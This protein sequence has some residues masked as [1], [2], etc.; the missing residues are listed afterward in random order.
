MTEEIVDKN[1]LDRQNNLTVMSAVKEYTDSMMVNKTY[2]GT[3]SFYI[4][5]G[6][7]YVGFYKILK[8]KFGGAYKIELTTKHGYQSGEMLEYKEIGSLEIY[9]S[10]YRSSRHIIVVASNEK[11]RERF[12]VVDAYENPENTDTYLY[13]ERNAETAG[14]HTTEFIIECSTLQKF[15]EEKPYS[16]VEKPTKGEYEEPNKI[17]YIPRNPWNWNDKVDQEDILVLNKYYTYNKQLISERQE[18]VGVTAGKVLTIANTEEVNKAIEKHAASYEPLRVHVFNET[19][20][21][22]LN[23]ATNIPGGILSLSWTNS[24]TGSGLSLAPDGTYFSLDD[25]IVKEDLRIGE[26]VTYYAFKEG[27]KWQAGYKISK[28]KSDITGYEVLSNKL[29]SWPAEVSD[30]NYPS[31]KLVK[32]SIKDTKITIANPA[33]VTYGSFTLNQTKEEI[34]EVPIYT[35]VDDLKSISKIEPLSANQG[36]VLD[37]IKSTCYTTEDAA[38][39]IL[40]DD[41]RIPEIEELSDLWNICER[42]KVKINNE[43]EDIIE[44]KSKANGNI[45]YLPIAKVVN[46]SEKMPRVSYGS[47]NCDKNGYVK[48]MAIGYQSS[49]PTAGFSSSEENFLGLPIRPVKESEDDFAIYMGTTSKD[50]NKLYWS[51]YNLYQYGLTKDDN[52]PGDN[53]AYGELETKKTF[54]S[55]N[56]NGILNV[57]KNLIGSAYKLN[58]AIRSDVY[59]N[60][61]CEI[62]KIKSFNGKIFLPKTNK[63]IF[64]PD[65]KILNVPNSGN[66]YI[67]SPII[68]VGKTLNSGH[69]G[70]KF[71]YGSRST[72]PP[73]NA[74]DAIVFGDKLNRLMQSYFRVELEADELLTVPDSNDKPLQFAFYD[75]GHVEHISGG[76]APTNRSQFN[77]ELADIGVGT[78][79]NYSGFFYPYDVLVDQLD[80]NGEPVRDESGNEIQIRATDYTSYNDRSLSLQSGIKWTG[81]L[82]SRE[83]GNIGSVGNGEEYNYVK[84]NFVNKLTIIIIP[85]H[86]N[87]TYTTL[88]LIRSDNGQPA[89]ANEIFKKIIIENN[90]E[91]YNI[92]GRKY[93]DSI[94]A[95]AEPY[96]YY[97]TYE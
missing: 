82:Y 35:P 29:T 31:A 79:L 32:D 90:P 65:V 88:D 78:G 85:K 49:I 87:Y 47:S 15:G 80:E 74:P 8:L 89:K 21:Y 54:T 53:F 16:I 7:S 13:L 93:R 72:Y 91:K 62:D 44:L 36:R 2:D 37:E 11:I 84:N 61:S 19:F 66:K 28:S 50:G 33:G 41:W 4:G 9:S 67:F 24:E 46:G 68:N 60:D 14:N 52:D 18:L 86:G 43:T 73:Y 38:R 56:Y 12:R 63:L 64:S 97:S 20:T 10:I 51:K 40:G 59:Y 42:K 95:I 1:K 27:D 3:S 30:D 25:I 57:N 55:A 23:I 69:N 6:H 92:N 58:A 94:T 17:V 96:E 45:I 83:K 75:P 26:T 70:V 81:G 22:D 34:I 39:N 48:V 71:I 5:T 76:S 77:N